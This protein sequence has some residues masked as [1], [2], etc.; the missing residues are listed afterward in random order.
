MH[1]KVNLLCIQH[2]KKLFSLLIY[3]QN[4]INKLNSLNHKIH[5]NLKVLI[6]TQ[7]TQY[8]S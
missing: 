3:Q 8:L 7:L 2:F 6:L 4:E 1:Q 5:K